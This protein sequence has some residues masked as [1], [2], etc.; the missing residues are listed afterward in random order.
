M[1]FKILKEYIRRVS[2]NYKIY[3]I[4]ILG[5]SIAIIASFHIYHFVYKELSVDGFHTKK[6]E[7]Y[8]VVNNDPNSNFRSAETFLPLGE[9]LKNQLPEVND[10]VRVI[11]EFPLKL[12]YGSQSEITNF[13]IIDPSFFEVL[14]FSLK[15]GSIK[16]FKETPNGIVITEKIAVKLFKNENPIGKTIAVSRN[17]SNNK[18]ELQVTGVINKIPKTS[19]IQGEYFIN[20]S[21]YNN[22]QGS[23]YKEMEW[24]ARD[25]ELYL[26]APNLS[27]N[28][29]LSKKITS[30]LLPKIKQPKNLAV[31]AVRANDIKEIDYQFD[32]QRLDTL[33]FDSLDISNQEKKGDYQ[34]V[35]VLILIVFLSLFLATSNYIIMNLGLN[36][37]RAKEFKTKRYLGASKSNIFFQFLIESIINTLICFVLTLV[38]Y[39][40]LDKIVSIIIESDYH[41]SLLN[42]GAFLTYFFLVIL[43]IASIIGGLEY[44][45]S[46]K[47]IFISSKEKEVHSKNA[48]FSKKIMI[49][50]QLVVFIC[51][52]ICI[53]FVGKQIN[54]I[55]SKNIGFDIKNVLSVSSIVKKDL[56][57][58]LESKSYVKHVSKG[59]PL[60]KTKFN[61]NKVF[62]EN[63]DVINTIMI[64]GD[65]NYLK[66]HDIKLLEGENINIIN[67]PT[68]RTMNSTIN[69]HVNF[70]DVLVNEE[71]VKRANLKNP[72]GT[73]LTLGEIKKIIIVG[74][75]QNIYNSP[76]YNPIQPIIIGSDLLHYTNVYQV[77]CEE[78][79]KTELISELMD[80]KKIQELPEEYRTRFIGSYNYSDI[81]K[82]ELQ[83]KRLL[84]AFTVIV[85]F[86]SVLGMIAIS[87]FITES[88]TK[89]I[90][91]RKVNGATIK[92][93]MLML[94]KDF[95][96]WVVIAFI[97]ACPI[98]YYAM[99]KWLEN[100]A[101]KTTLSWW[102][103]ALAGLFTLVIALLTVS[104]Q[105]YRA[106]TRNPV[107]SLR[108][109]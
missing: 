105:T 55:Q 77:S 95:I 66:V 76:L 2:R 107:E 47:S 56:K 68:K 71:F 16:N 52:S 94:N 44:L 64:Q 46:Y 33:Y 102:V 37:N 74:V 72:I 10:Y 92:E 93:I 18:S 60:F 42:D 99:S 43:M 83:L 82:K 15:S 50:F 85:L 70:Y 28:K 96:K 36:L 9:L 109:E 58:F 35:R 87:L 101:Y 29:A 40:F 88:K 4:S 11:P 67:K 14:D 24:F 7:I 41:F 80:S 81:Y 49:V 32:L 22:L 57:N 21:S 103:F 8:R 59:Q 34:F 73:V 90:G 20:I 48:W 104:W 69:H 75:F 5:M 27:D 23:D 19:T 12:Y 54:Y 78:A 61:L 3:A 97:I 26:Y 98:A 1:I 89:E 91:I 84:E 63:E 17:N 86:I 51:L 25:T 38:S 62:L 100:F 79:Y 45:F 31:M 13:S 108:D 53:L 65:E 106:A 39:P 6:K 30:T